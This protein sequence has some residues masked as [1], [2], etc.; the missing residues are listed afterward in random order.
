LLLLI[1]KRG[2]SFS[3]QEAAIKVKKQLVKNLS[4]SENFTAGDLFIPILFSSQILN[5]YILAII[6]TYEF[7][8]IFGRN[9]IQIEN[10]VDIS[11][12]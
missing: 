9:K 12:K 7:R 3:N 4:K 5:I 8:C 6:I 11:P 1:S 10:I 2:K